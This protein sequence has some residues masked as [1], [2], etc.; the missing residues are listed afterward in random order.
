MSI[1]VSPASPKPIFY[2]SRQGEV[3]NMDPAEH[4]APSCAEAFRI[5]NK[6]HL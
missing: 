5:K 2:A 6:P 4:F 3:F 1:C